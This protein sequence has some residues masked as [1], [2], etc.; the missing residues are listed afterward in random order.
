M[1]TFFNSA[2]IK[3]LFI[4]ASVLISSLSMA[5]RAGQTAPYYEEKTFDSAVFPSALP[6]KMWVHI[7]KKSLN[8]PVSVE[9]RDARGRLVASEWYAKN[10]PTV[11]VRFDLSDVGDGIYTFRISDGRQVQERTFKLATPGF[12]EQLPKRLI[13]MN[14]PV[15][16]VGDTQAN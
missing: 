2:S 8:R 5:Q 10:R 3:A 6:S 16:S 9:L 7:D 11:R 14:V 12:E 15:S 1:K 13:T 4:G